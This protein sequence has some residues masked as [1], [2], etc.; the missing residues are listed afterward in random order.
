MS[1]SPSLPGLPAGHPFRPEQQ[2]LL[3]RLLPS[4]DGGQVQW[5][6]GFWAGLQ[7]ARGGAVET[8]TTPSASPAEITILYGSE[9]GNAEALAQ[10]VSTRVRQEG[11]KPQVI[12]MADAKI[13]R[14]AASKHLLVLVST[15]GEGD[16]P[17]P[18]EDYFSA[19]MSKRAPQCPSTAFSVLAL[20]DTSYE[21]FCKIG[22]DF[23][24]RLE[25]LG[26][27]RLTPRVDCD[28]DFEAP[29]QKW[30]QE[31][32]TVLKAEV[33]TTPTP[34]TTPGL[35]PAH[36]APTTYDRKKP[37]PAALLENINLNSPA[38]ETLKG[39]SK[40]TRH[41]EISLANSGLTY[42]PGDS[43]GIYPR[44]CPEVVDD[45]LALTKLDPNATVSNPESEEV[46]LRE[47]LLRDYDITGLSQLFLKKYA[48]LVKSE[49]LDALLAE[50][51]KGN[52]K[53]YLYGREISDSLRD[54]PVE[55]L[56][57]QDLVNL[58]RRMPPRLYSIASSLKAHPDEVHLTVATVRYQ[59]NGRLR[60]GVCST[61][62]ADRVGPDDRIP[63]FVHHNKNFRL[64]TDPSTPIIMV[65][66]GTGI[67]PFRA[68]V[69]E[70]REI[71]SRGQNWLFFGDQHFATDFLYQAEWQQALADGTLHRLDL[72]FSRDT[73]KKVYVQHRMQEKARD[74]WA[75][76]QEGAYFYVCGDASRMAKDVHETLLSIARQQG[77][78]SEDQS[79]D[80]IKALQK[81]KRY[82]RDVY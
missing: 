7:M 27:R 44:N 19:F 70:R 38:S 63:V 39:S 3:N 68:F 10:Q 46:T 62:L 75:W 61:Y 45:I 13:D 35:A 51:D 31:V 81:D 14:L 34:G 42:E 26:A 71:G 69:E 57:P 12:N 17:S 79:H 11:F 25:A 20:G 60:K 82:Q 21:H 78:L 33:Q 40:E 56:S 8:V 58:L 55:D 47:A 65:G 36:A 29:F 77:G 22:K 37:F 43:L 5:L 41:L 24:Q 72:A 54:F 32:I 2:E 67:A 76:L 18:A 23:D 30:L 59:S 50:K 52:L 73:E 9:S 53:S 48:A 74:L 1:S 49:H 64:P 4:L 6:G 66:P 28:V 15:W 80:W 16:P